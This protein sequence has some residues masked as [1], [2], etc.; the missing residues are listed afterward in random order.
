LTASKTRSAKDLSEMWMKMHWKQWMGEAR[1]LTLPKL[2]MAAV[3]ALVLALGLTA[4]ENVSGYSRTTLVRVIDASYIAPA[5]NV[6]VEGTLFAGDIGE[7]TITP[8]GTI[9]PSTAAAI[10]VTAVTGTTALVQTTGALLAGYQHSVFLTDNSAAPTKYTVTMLEDQVTAAP[11]GQSA[12]RFLNQAIQTGAVDIYM[13]PASVATPITTTTKGVTTTT[14]SLDGVIPL[15]TNL[16]VGEAASYINFASQT[17]TMVITPTGVTTPTY[18]SPS[19][20]LIGGEV[21]TVVIV[22]SQLTSNPPVAVVVAK[23]VN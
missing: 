11:S 7:G 8:Y 10:K 6:Y 4:C 5:V 9:T 13:V 3:T 22:D 19:L 18:I 17:V 20:F 23:D 12:F 16:P 14:I 21:R 15:V 2:A 1:Q